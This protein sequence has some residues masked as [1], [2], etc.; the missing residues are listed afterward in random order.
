MT[1]AMLRV[2]CAS[3]LVAGALDAQG[4]RHEIGL[5]LRTFE[6]ALE[7]EA[8]PARRDAAFLELERAVQAFFGLDMKRVASSI[9]AASLARLTVQDLEDL[10]VDEEK[11]GNTGPVQTVAW[12]P[13]RDGL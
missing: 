13:S 2:V 6:R 1:R 7:A 10:S 4:D 12:S 11:S 8:D 3:L 9:D 5:R